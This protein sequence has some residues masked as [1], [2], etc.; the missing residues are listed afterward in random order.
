MTSFTKLSA[1]S[2]QERRLLAQALLLLPVSGLALRLVSLRRWQAILSGFAPRQAPVA[3]ANREAQPDL[4]GTVARMVRAAAVR[5]PY[6]APCLPRAVTVWWLLR[7]VGLESD[8]R[9]GVRRHGDRLEAHAWV[10]CRGQDLDDWP[11]GGRPFA[12]LERRS[13]PVETEAR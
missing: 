12:R 13:T 8:I 2:A 5:G 7:R 10:E 3:E 4:A 9:F 6:R 1:L 11:D